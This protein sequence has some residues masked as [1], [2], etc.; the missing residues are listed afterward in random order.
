MALH[1]TRTLGIILLS[2]FSYTAAADTIRIAQEH[3]DTAAFRLPMQV[4]ENALSQASDPARIEWADGRGWL[5]PRALT[6]LKSCDAPFDVY[7]TGYDKS[8]EAH[9]LQVNVPLTLGLLGVRGFVTTAAQLDSVKERDA[10][11]WAIGSGLGWPDTTIMQHAGYD[12]YQAPFENL[13]KMLEAKRI[14]VF[15]RGV[16]E[17]QLEIT[18]RNGSVVLVDDVLML[19][20]FAQ[21]L[22]VS[23]CR[24]ELHAQ[25][26]TALIEAYEKGQTELMLRT[27]PDVIFTLELLGDPEVQRIILENTIAS[28]AFMDL[29]KRYFLEEI[30]ELLWPE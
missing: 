1:C 9:L 18:Q 10:G 25:L 7:F 19:Y 20:P 15:Q 24:P 11:E 13:W 3:Y 27:H 2:S 29:G 4:I 8:R 28:E 23:P 22:Y 21:F 16:Q 6:I 12:V 26:E 30:R 14:D 5:Q 17:A